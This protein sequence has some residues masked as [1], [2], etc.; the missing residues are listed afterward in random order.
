MK[1]IMGIMENLRTNMPKEIAGAKVIKADYY[2]KSMSFDLVNGTETKII[3][4]VSNVLCYYLEDGSSLIV[5]PSG[6]EPKIKIY[7]SAVGETNE[8]AKVKLKELE[9]SG[10]TLLGF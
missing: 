8:K 2:E 5:R 10:T 3:L 7:L 1:Q 9:Q 6:T 4:P